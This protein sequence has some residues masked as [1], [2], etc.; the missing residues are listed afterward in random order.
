VTA[1]QLQA[2]IAE[3]AS[4][5]DV[6]TGP[7]EFAPRPGF[8]PKPGEV[9]DGDFAYSLKVHLAFSRRLA[10]GSESLPEPVLSVEIPARV[11]DSLTRGYSHMFR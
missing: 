10:D 4:R 1:N 7:T 5:E 8:T 2:D 3:S 9:V 6:S 11:R